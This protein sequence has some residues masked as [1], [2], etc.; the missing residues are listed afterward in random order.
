MVSALSIKC[1]S[2]TE[3]SP[4]CA[5]YKLLTYQSREFDLD[6]TRRFFCAKCCGAKCYLKR[7]SPQMLRREVPLKRQDRASPAARAASSF[8][9]VRAGYLMVDE[10]CRIVECEPAVSALSN[11]EGDPQ[12]PM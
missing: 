1:P 10:S 6:Q 2:M 12:L 3:P 9:K 7:V 5:R 11:G 4:V 8:I